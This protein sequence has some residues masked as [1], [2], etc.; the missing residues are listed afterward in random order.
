V[1][2]FVAIGGALIALLTKKGTNAT[3]GDVA[4]H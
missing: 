1:A 3:E 4:M 2:G